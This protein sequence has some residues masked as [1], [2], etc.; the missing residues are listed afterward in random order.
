MQEWKGM[1]ERVDSAWGGVERAIEG[2]ACARNRRRADIAY[3]SARILDHLLLSETGTVG[4]RV[5]RIGMGRRARAGN[6]PTFC[7]WSSTRSSILLLLE[8]RRH[9]GAQII[10]NLLLLETGGAEEGA[11]IRPNLL[12]TVDVARRKGTMT[13]VR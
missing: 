10:P 12:P 11:S 6:D 2:F 9:G 5:G 1:E 4:R 3:G 13:T 8:T 7:Y